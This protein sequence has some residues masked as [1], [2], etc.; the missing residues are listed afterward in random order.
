MDPSRDPRRVGARPPLPEDLDEAL[1]RTFDAAGPESQRL[2]LVAAIDPGVPVL[3]R[4]DTARLRQARTNFL[5]NAVKFTADG[6]VVGAG[7][8]GPGDEERSPS[9]SR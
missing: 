1:R 8:L 2:D 5:S 6:Q 7:E 4:G 9:G 3:M